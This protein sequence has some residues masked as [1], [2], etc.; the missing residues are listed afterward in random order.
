MEIGTWKGITGRTEVGLEEPLRVLLHVAA[1][2]GRHGG[3]PARARRVPTLPRQGLGFWR[4]APGGLRELAE[5]RRAERRSA[6]GD[7]RRG[8][9]SP[10]ANGEEEVSLE[11]ASEPRV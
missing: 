2:D 7:G 6:G 4:S 1:V 5:E 9:G 10:D 11:L 3:R 8:L